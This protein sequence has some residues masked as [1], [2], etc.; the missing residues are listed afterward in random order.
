MI[1]L[2]E[3]Y[4][5]DDTLYP[6]DPKAKAV[7]NQRLYFDMGTL[8][9]KQSIFFKAVMAKESEEK[10]AETKKGMEGAVELL[11]IFLEG[12]DYVAGNHLTLAD[13]SIVASISTYELIGID[14][15]KF[16]NVAKWYAKCQQEV[17]GYE[18]NLE[19]LEMFKNLMAS[20]K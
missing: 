10:I 17:P 7:V 1:Y 15:N 18:V 20:M 4:A 3:K 6:K 8:Y 19:G 11:N 9:D 14:V 16:S 13:L 2:A 12:N 5:K